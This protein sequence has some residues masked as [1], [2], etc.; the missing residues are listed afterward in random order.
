MGQSKANQQVVV[1]VTN[2]QRPSTY[3]L[4]VTASTGWLNGMAAAS[5]LTGN[6]SQDISPG[7]NDAKIVLLPHRTV[8]DETERVVSGGWFWLLKS[9]SC[10]ALWRNSHSWSH[11]LVGCSGR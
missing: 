11:A 4:L 8:Q 7:V 3:C 2:D 10:F 5:V 9:S 6:Y 1:V